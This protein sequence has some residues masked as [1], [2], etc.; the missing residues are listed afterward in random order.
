[1]QLTGAHLALH[2][3]REALT[4]HRTKALDKPYFR[5]F[6]SAL[7]LASLPDSVL[8]PT[9][10]GASDEGMPTQ[11]EDEVTLST[12][13]SMRLSPTSCT[14]TIN[15]ISLLVIHLVNR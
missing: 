9:A 3:F 1:M 7:S 11:S 12:Y 10:E 6:P 5:F 2:K 14:D 8:H 13:L 4:K 15:N